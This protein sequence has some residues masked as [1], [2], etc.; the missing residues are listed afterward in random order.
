M[1]K[2]LAW[3]L[4]L[5]MRPRRS[6]YHAR[7]VVGVGDKVSTVCGSGWVSCGFT[8]HPLLRGGTDLITDAKLITYR[9]VPYKTPIAAS[10]NFDI[11][12][13]LLRDDDVSLIPQW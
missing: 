4:R 2:D 5:V 11:A 6:N 3:L 12:D 10:V 9:Q 7:L 13:V 1:S 8:T